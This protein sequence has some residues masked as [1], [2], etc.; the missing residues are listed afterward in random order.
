[1]H[2]A[3]TPSSRLRCRCDRSPPRLVRRHRARP[4]LAAHARPVRDPRQRGDAAADA[5]RSRRPAL[6]ALAR[7]LAD[8]G[9]S[10][11]CHD[12]RGDRRVAGARLQPARRHAAP[13]GARCRRARL[14]RRPD[15]AARRRA[16]HRGRRREL[17]V[18]ARRAARSTR[19]SAACRSAPAS[20]STAR[21]RRRCSTSGPPSASRACHAAASCPLA[22]G[23]PSRGQ[24]FEPRASS[25]RSRD[26][27][28]SAARSRCGR[29]AGG[30]AL[31]DEEA[32]ASLHRDGLVALRADGAA[33]LPETG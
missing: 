19:T 30:A 10:R 33:V 9:G 31:D 17:R 24:R 25:R 8:R 15:G 27:S 12:R 20:R 7:A 29:C 11:G 22:D 1:M 23:C 5:G 13:R 16:V 6:P 3:C 18:R 4:P 32:I 21:A 26:R 28:G 2:L 14:A